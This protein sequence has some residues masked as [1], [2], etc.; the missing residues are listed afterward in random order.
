[1]VRLLDLE[2]RDDLKGWRRFFDWKVAAFGA[3]VMGGIVAWINAD[4][5]VLGALTASLKQA[6]YTFFFSGLTMRLCERLATR[7]VPGGLA[8]VAAVAVPSTLAIGATFVIHSLR[9][10]PEPLHSTVPTMIVSP[11]SFAI[12]GTV[13]RRSLGR[14]AG[15]WPVGSRAGD[16]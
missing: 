13:K 3:S 16:R 12:W 11:L 9:G 14:R 8:L 2:A 5:G 1:M 4:H 7:P 10:T 6:A 15:A